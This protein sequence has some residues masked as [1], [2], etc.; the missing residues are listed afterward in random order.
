MT[1]S[2]KDGAVVFSFFRPAAREVSLAG[3]FNQWA[4]QLPLQRD[5]NGWWTLRL[6]LEPG[7]YAFRYVADGEWYTDFASHGVEVTE[8]GWNSL[9]VVPERPTGAEK[10]KQTTHMTDALLIA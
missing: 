2:D 1:T 4:K 7:E 9:L 8:H 6:A 3:D 5:P 10:K